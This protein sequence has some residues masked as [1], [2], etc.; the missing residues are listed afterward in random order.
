VTSQGEDRR[1]GRRHQVEGV[2]GRLQVAPDAVIFDVSVGG[3]AVETSAW[4]GIGRPYQ[5]RLSHGD[6]LLPLTGMVVW[7]RLVRTERLKRGETRPTYRAGIRFQHDEESQRALA[8]LIAETAVVDVARRMTGRFKV[9]REEAVNVSFVR[10]F[11]VVSLGRSQM[12]LEADLLLEVG[13][14]Y[15]LELAGEADGEPVPAT[16][17]V[18]GLSQAKDEKS[19]PTFRIQTEILKLEDSA[20][21]LLERI[22]RREVATPNF[23]GNAATGVFHRPGCQHADEAGRRFTSRLAALEAGLRPGQCCSP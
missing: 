8:A 5:I 10:E 9:R 1:E 2:S 15:D 19:R 6:E 7:C 23:F 21:E 3:M 20:R 16:V 12:V 11:R 17:R 14:R 18:L 22:I 4:L 13:S